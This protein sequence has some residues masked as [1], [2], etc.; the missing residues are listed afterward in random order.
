MALPLILAGPIVR[1]VEPRLVAIWV[2]LNSEARVKVSVWQQHQFA[3]GTPGEVKSG[4]APWATAEEDTRRVGENLHIALITVAA[5]QPL[6]ALAP[7]TTCAYDVL[8]KIGSDVVDLKG[9]G[10]LRDEPGD[11]D[12]DDRPPQPA[13]GYTPDRL[14]S[15][16]TCPA[17]LDDLVIAHASCRKTTG[18]GHDAMAYLDQV[19]ETNIGV[20]T[21][22][23][24]Q[25]FLTGDQIYADTVSMVLLPIL[26]EVGN[27]LFG[28]FETLPVMKDGDTSIS[29]V[30]SSIGNFPAE[31]RRKLVQDVANFTTSSGG[32]HLLSLAE[33]C[34]M[35]LAA[36][37]PAV[38]REFPAAGDI[39]KETQSV[40]AGSL[41]E[42]ERCHQPHLKGKTK[43][44]EPDKVV[45]VASW[46]LAMTRKPGS[47]FN[48]HV[49]L[50][51]LYR[52]AV[53][54][55]RRALAN[56]ATYMIFD[57]HE[58]TDDWNLT[59]QWR[60]Q[61]NTSPLG[62]T[63]VRNGL[64]AY[65]MFQG[66]GNDPVRFAKNKGKKL[67]DAIEE[68]MPAAGQ[69]PATTPGND[70]DVMLGLAGSDPEVDWH[71]TIDGPLHRVAVLDT[72][73][74]RRFPGRVSPPELVGE[75]LAKQV[76]GT[77][78][79]AGIE[80]LVVVSAVPVL[81][82]VIIDQIGQ[83]LRI[84]AEEFRVYVGRVLL[85]KEKGPCE[86]E[87][88]IKGFEE[89]DAESWARNEIAL[90]EILKRLAGHANV[91][92]L[93]GD[94][95]Y[96]MS[97]VLDFW[98][99]GQT[100]AAGSRIVQLTSSGTRNVFKPLVEN[101]I[102]AAAVGQR[103]EA[104]GLPAVRFAWED[105]AQDTLAFPTGS[106]VRPGI[107]ARLN[108]D[109]VL[110][111]GNGW[112]SGTTVATEPDYRWRLDLIRDDRTDAERPAALASPGTLSADF[113]ENDPI[114]SYFDL[115]ARH[116]LAAAEHYY[117][118]RQIVF[119][120]NIG[121]VRFPVEGAANQVR[122]ELL[123]ADP[124]DPRRATR[125]FPNTVHQAPLTPPAEPPPELVTLAPPEEPSDG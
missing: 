47:G 71:Y 21:E 45:G 100:A 64:V 23:P 20:P 49:E 8:V 39:F 118:L 83:P 90:E 98:K 111:S 26:N 60:N 31:R 42:Q 124:T 15:F 63:I 87:D 16:V 89:F 65:A 30:E 103:M 123:S 25:L 62:R 66:W 38:W 27:E 104:I 24:H 113:G 17:S 77:P 81:G 122:H 114:D 97:M 72:R 78:L 36:W 96:A 11:S 101:L 29:E 37:S 10:L 4:D 88:L 32:N 3:T 105:S 2:A 54:F 53:P 70:V 56:V 117:H 76:P 119:P 58:I 68:L 18:P 109:P 106:S 93:S 94:V 108:R 99:K 67:L 59:Q 14:P 46:A 12:E 85:G 19:I 91:V 1:R 55:V 6:P 115:A 7:G 120:N 22:R 69:A 121:L 110:V 79:D 82:P 74:R 34:A 5:K 92:V 125:D 35:Y 73:T 80:L 51:K 107:R 13:L 84:V 33:Y 9:A 57:D 48:K 61:V 102:R 40:V 44:S 95:H 112:P 52:R 75:T 41:T 43:L 86:P 28:R 116:S 50:T